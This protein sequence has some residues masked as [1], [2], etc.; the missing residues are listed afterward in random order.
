MDQP[1]E[2]VVEPIAKEPPEN[3]QKTATTAVAIAPERKT[4]CDGRY[5][6]YDLCKMYEVGLLNLP[7][8]EHDR[9]R[10]T[11]A[12]AASAKGVWAI[13]DPEQVH[14]LAVFWRTKNPHVNLAREFP[15]PDPDGRFIY[16]G[17]AWADLRAIPDLKKY[18]FSKYGKDADYL[19]WHDQRAKRRKKLRGRLFTLA[20]PEQPIGLK[21]VLAA[22]N[23][24]SAVARG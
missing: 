9:W 23:G 24:H 10:A 7:P 16:I 3:H 15:K 18:L 13:V 21:D 4:L 1:Q 8:K 19:A 12:G 2:I 20:I 14:A 22:R 5:N 6:L 11:F 17:W